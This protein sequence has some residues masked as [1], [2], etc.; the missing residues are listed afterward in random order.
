L[1][2]ADS[3]HLHL[4]DEP[5]DGLNGGRGPGECRVRPKNDGLAR[6][7]NTVSRD[8]TDRERIRSCPCGSHVTQHPERG[9]EKAQGRIGPPQ[10]T[11]GGGYG[12]QTGAKPRST[13][14]NPRSVALFQ[15]LSGRPIPRPIPS[16][17]DERPSARGPGRAE[18]VNGRE[19][20]NETRKN[21]A[22]ERSMTGNARTPVAGANLRRVE[23]HERRRERRRTTAVPLQR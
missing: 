1:L 10:K 20:A 18:A 4:T 13:S 19:G 2:A 16:G 15:T 22:H 9:D 5:R 21:R 12:P 17:V 3:E 23:P 14:A 6:C 11:N 7:A 8:A